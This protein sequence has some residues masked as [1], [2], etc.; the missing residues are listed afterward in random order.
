[1]ESF[2]SDCNTAASQLLS[3]T[4]EVLSLKEL[5]RTVLEARSLLGRHEQHIAGVLQQASVCRLC[6]E[7]YAETE[8]NQLQ[9]DVQRLGD[10]AIIFR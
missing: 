8:L 4:D 3:S 6:T 5:P 2:I 1:L 9:T 7:Q 10:N